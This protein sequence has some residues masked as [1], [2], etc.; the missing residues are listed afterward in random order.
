MSSGSSSGSTS[1]R[2]MTVAGNSPELRQHTNICHLL[3]Y[4]FLLKPQESITCMGHYFC[5]PSVLLRGLPRIILNDFDKCVV[6]GLFILQMKLKQSFFMFS[7]E[8][9]IVRT[10]YSDV[11]Y[12]HLRSSKFHSYDFICLLVTPGL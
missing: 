8:Q 11:T 10:N 6:Q 9:I 4:L 12:R 2:Y 3:T 7:K 5:C 1:L